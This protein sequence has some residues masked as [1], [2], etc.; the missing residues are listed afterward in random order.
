MRV[1]EGLALKLAAQLRTPCANVAG[2]LIFRSNRTARN[3]WWKEWQ[4]RQNGWERDKLKVIENGREY[5]VKCVALRLDV[6]IAWNGFI[7]QLRR[8]GTTEWK[9][10][11]MCCS[12]IAKGYYQLRHVRL[13]V[14]PTAWNNT[15]PTGLIFMKFDILVFFF[16]KQSIKIQVSLKSYKNNRY[17]TWRPIYIFYH[18]SLSSS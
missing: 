11:F 6:I 13:Y 8:C 10:V 1:V 2:N 4:G 17:D 9:C 7:V 12:T 15:A 5:G 18:I 3:L 16:E 14:R